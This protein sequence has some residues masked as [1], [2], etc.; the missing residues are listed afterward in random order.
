MIIEVA[1]RK[2]WVCPCQRDVRL[3]EVAEHVRI[4]K[5]QTPFHTLMRDGHVEDHY[6]IRG[7]VVRSRPEDSARD[8]LAV[9]IAAKKPEIDE[10]FDHHLE[11]MHAV[12]IISRRKLRESLDL[13]VA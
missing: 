3:D 9:A 7:G 6:V 11:K 2:M 4:H 5:D 8:M 1:A 10:V 12:G 13:D